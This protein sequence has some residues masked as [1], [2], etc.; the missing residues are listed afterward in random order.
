MLPTVG[1]VCKPPSLLA[2]ELRDAYALSRRRKRRKE[3]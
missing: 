3:F 1:E 2:V